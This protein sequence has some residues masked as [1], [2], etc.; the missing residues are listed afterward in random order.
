MN[1]NAFI[2]KQQWKYSEGAHI[3]DWLNE[4]S[5]EIKDRM[6]YTYQGKA[7]I[8]FSLGKHLYIKKVE[9]KEIGLYINKS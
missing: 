8:V 7:K 5:F 1:S 2:G 4:S 3:G 9:T 6:I